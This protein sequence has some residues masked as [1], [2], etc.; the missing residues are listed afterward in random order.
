V[1]FLVEKVALGRV[2]IEYFNFFP[3]NMIP[4]LFIFIYVLFLSDGQIGK[5]WEPSKSNAISEIGVH[6]L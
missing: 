2:F 6:W 1:G 5:A 4:P 3:F